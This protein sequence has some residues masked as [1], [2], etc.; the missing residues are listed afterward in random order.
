MKGKWVEICK[1]TIYMVAK[2]KPQHNL[3]ASITASFS[4]ALTR[5]CPQMSCWL[6]MNKCCDDAHHLRLPYATLYQLNS[7][8]IILCS[9]TQLAHL[10]S[11]KASWAVYKD[12]RGRNA[13]SMPYA[14]LCR[15]R[16]QIASSCNVVKE[17]G[18][19]SIIGSV[20]KLE[21]FRPREYKARI[22]LIYHE[23]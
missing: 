23:H 11:W 6:P 15:S 4:A 2:M 7:G 16:K 14:T 3:R 10:V 12:E 17:Y 19:L 20:M 5:L 13:P 21:S 18:Y 9:V 8:C 22:Y 1:P